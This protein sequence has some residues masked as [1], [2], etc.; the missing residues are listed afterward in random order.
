MSGRFSAAVHVPQTVIYG[1]RYSCD[2][3]SRARALR[4][5]GETQLSLLFRPGVG[6][7]EPSPSSVEG[8][9]SRLPMRGRYAVRVQPR[10]RI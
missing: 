2:I 9:A 1:A 3:W 8:L 7:R 5:R 4:S 10:G 6:L